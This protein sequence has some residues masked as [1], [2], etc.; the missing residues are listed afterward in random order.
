M[1]VKNRGKLIISL[2][3]N[4]LAWHC[5]LRGLGRV[6]IQNIYIIT[7]SFVRGVVGLLIGVFM[8]LLRELRFFSKPY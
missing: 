2:G 4:T 6:T 3:R 7:I 1:G 5:H 8:H